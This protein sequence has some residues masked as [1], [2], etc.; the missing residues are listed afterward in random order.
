MRVSG[1]HAFI[2][3]ASTGLGRA[4]AKELAARGY[5]LTLV[6]RRKKLLNELKKELKGSGRQVLIVQADVVDWGALEAAVEQAETEIGPID[7]LV[8]NAGVA[9]PSFIKDYNPENVRQVIEV[10][11]LGL[12]QTVAAV[13]PRFIKR[14]KGQVVGISSLASYVSL[15]GFSVYSASK[16]AVSSYLDGLRLELAPHKITVSTVC[17]GFIKTP[18][19]DKNKF[20]MPFLQEVDDA[21]KHIVNK[22]ERKAEWINFPEPL[23]RTI[24][25]LNLLPKPLIKAILGR[26]VLQKV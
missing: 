24:Q 9:H 10:N 1:K 14:K 7:L 25:G 23:F 18:M 3:G 5:D 6:A 16:A 21:A 2:T 26:G 4:L 15:P 17:P 13:A 22:I 19:T 11:V 8:A 20:K 12:M